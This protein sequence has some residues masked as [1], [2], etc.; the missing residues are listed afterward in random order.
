VPRQTNTEAIRELDRTV[1]VLRERTNNLAEAVN[2][3]ESAHSRT[4][5]ALAALT[6]RVAIL[7]ERHADQRKA[8]EESDRKRWLLTLAVLGTFLAL[9]ANIALSFVRK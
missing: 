5:E 6:T 3:I 8:L 4:A 1:V 9:L 7:E 2:R